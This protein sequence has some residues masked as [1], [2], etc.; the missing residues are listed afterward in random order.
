MFSNDNFIT[1]FLQLINTL[2]VTRN[3]RPKIIRFDQLILTHI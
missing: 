3:G 1:P 2:E